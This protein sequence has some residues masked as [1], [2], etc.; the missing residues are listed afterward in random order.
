MVSHHNNAAENRLKR[1]KIFVNTFVN[2]IRNPLVIKPASN[3]QTFSSR[4]QI[5]PHCVRFNVHAIAE[6]VISE[7]AF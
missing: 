7:I 5:C 1:V 3:V 2:R 4:W 6:R